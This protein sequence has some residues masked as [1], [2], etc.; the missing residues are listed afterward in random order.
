MSEI[1]IEARRDRAIGHA[2]AQI[3]LG[4]KPSTAIAD[5]IEDATQVRITADL[6]RAIRDEVP[7][8]AYGDVVNVVRQFCGIAGF[9]VIE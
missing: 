7:I 8:V 1:Q 4:G 9:E 2:E 6:V 3:E 5:A